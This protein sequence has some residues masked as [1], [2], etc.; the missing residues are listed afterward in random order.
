M[1]F[2]VFVLV[3]GALIAA[4]WGKSVAQGFVAVV[5]GRVGGF[6][7]VPRLV[8]RRPAVHYA[9]HRHEPRSQ[10]LGRSD[11]G[12]KRFFDGRHELHSGNADPEIPARHRLRP[13]VRSLF[14][15]RLPRRS[16]S[17]PVSGSS[18][19][20]SLPMKTPQLGCGQ[21]SVSA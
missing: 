6:A 11:A 19:G 1:G 12:P 18:R 7:R 3:L 21:E 4:I 2:I 16:S 5:P 20:R 17:G 14:H 8:Y 13:K 10:R 9:T 15:P